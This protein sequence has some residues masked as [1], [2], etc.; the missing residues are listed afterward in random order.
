ME[1]AEDIESSCNTLIGALKEEYEVVDIV[2]DIS[3]IIKEGGLTHKKLR[4]ERYGGDKY[5]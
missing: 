5:D 1:V 4:E 2:E 3:G